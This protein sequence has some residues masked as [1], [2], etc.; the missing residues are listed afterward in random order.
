VFAILYSFSPI[1]KASQVE[2]N[3]ICFAIDEFGD[4]LLGLCRPR[5]WPENEGMIERNHQ[6]AAPGWQD[7]AKPNC[8]SELTHHSLR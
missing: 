7:A 1:T 8:F 3:G 6:A 4:L 5:D 2:Q